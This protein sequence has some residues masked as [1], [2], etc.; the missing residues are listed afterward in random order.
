MSV[1]INTIESVN[2]CSRVQLII[3]F[4]VAPS[5]LHKSRDKILQALPLTV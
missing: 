4:A 1:Y 5:K 3:L 2:L